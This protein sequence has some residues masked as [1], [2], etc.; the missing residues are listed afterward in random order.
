MS[1][2]PADVSLTHHWM[3]RMRGGE[4]VLEQFC[5]MFPTAE[6]SCL[7][8]DRDGLSD[9]INR[10]PIFASFLQRFKLARNYYKHL[11]PFHPFLIG[12]MRVSK[13]AKMV[14]ASDAS[15]IKGVKVPKDCTLVCYCHSPPRYIWEMSETY[16]SKKAGMGAIAR[17]A[18]RMTIPICRRFDRKAAKRVDLFIA[19]SRF[20]SDRIERFY[21][22]K[23]VVVHPPV[24]I[25]DFG[26]QRRRSSF[27][28]VVS[29]LVPYKRIDVAIEA[30]NKNGLPLVIIGDGS[31]KKRLEELAANNITFLGRQSFDV[32]K[33]NYETCRGFVFPGVEDFGITP[34]EAQAAGAPVVAFGK[35]GALET[36]IDGETG[37]FFSEQTG[38]SL[39]DA[40]SRLENMYSEKDGE[41]AAQCR[42]N[43]EKFDAERFRR[44][45][46]EAI[47]KFS[48]SPDG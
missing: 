18:F 40:L 43:A 10:H 34:L 20:V 25:E 38:A 8:F 42:S 32:L 3:F 29:E 23:S 44:E 6:I 39:N 27:F 41:I 24:A 19:N 37:V 17:A 9:E 4:K 12:Q 1:Y 2:V 47:S 16:A 11:L 22:T 21:N 35:G 15:M 7:V 46:A 36:V 26:F 28:L 13:R 45:I 48:A 31:E 14:I 33:E 5:K 30:F